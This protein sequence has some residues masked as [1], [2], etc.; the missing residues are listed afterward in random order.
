MELILMALF[1]T[2]LNKSKPIKHMATTGI[3]NITIMNMILKQRRVKNSNYIYVK[4][5][6]TI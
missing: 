4:N 3:I 5:T 1:L 6:K 2:V